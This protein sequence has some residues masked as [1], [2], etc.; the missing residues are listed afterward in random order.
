MTAPLMSGQTLAELADSISGAD[1]PIHMSSSGVMS[2]D[3]H[4]Q[5][6]MCVKGCSPVKGDGLTFD[7]LQP[8]LYD[9][10]I[11]AQD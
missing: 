3:G 9:R 7:R 5:A 4:S 10:R 8:C 6:V 1:L 11:V 2:V